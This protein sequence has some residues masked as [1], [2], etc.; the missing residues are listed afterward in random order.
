MPAE[1]HT[2]IELAGTDRPGLL[3]EV[4]AVLADLHCNVVNAEIWTHNA[5]A[6]AVVHVTDDSMGCAI[7]D[8]KR[9]STIK[10]LLCN[11]LKGSDDLKTAKTT[12]SAPGVMHRERR[13]HQIM[14]ADRDYERVEKA[15]VRAVEEGSSRPQ[16]TLLNIE[17]DY[18]VVTMRSKDRPKLLFDIVCTLTD[19]QYVVFH[20]MVN[21]GRIEAYQRKIDADVVIQFVLEFYSEFYIRHVDGLPISSE[22]E[23]V[24]VIQ[25][26]EAAIER[27]ASEGLELELC[28]DDRLGL[29][30]DITR[31]FRE[32]SLCI[33]RALISTKGGKAKD[34]FYVTDVTGNPVDPKIIDS[35]RAQIGHTALQVKFMR[36]VTDLATRIGRALIS[37]SNHATP[38]PTWTPSLEQTLLRLGCRE[39]LTPS[40]VA[41]VI[42]SFPFTHHSLALGFFNWA[43]R[44]PGFSHDSISYQSILKSLSSSRQFNAIEALLKQVKAQKLSLDPSVYRF[45]I[46]SLIKG[47]KTQNAIWVFNEVNSL[48]AELGSELCN[49]LLATSVSDGYFVESQKV[50]DEMFQKGIV[51]NTIGLGLFIW[52]TCKN[53]ELSKVLSLLDEV[54]KGSSWDVNGSIIAVLVVHGLCFSSRESEAFWALDELR[55]RGC[56]PDFIAY[57]IVAEAFRM[58][59]N[60]VERELVLKKKR[61]LGVAPRSN[62]YREFILGL[63]LERRISE[64][65]DLGEAIVSGNFPIEDDVLNALIG[66]VSRIDPGS[67]IMFLNFMVGKGRLPTLS[68]LSNLSKNLCK[69][70]KGDELWE[71]YQVLSSHGYFSDLESYNVMVSFFCRAGRLREAYKVLQEMKTKGLSPNVL[72]YN[73]LMEACCKEDLVRPAKRLWDEMFA[74]GCPGNLSTYNILIGKLSQIGEV[75]E[76]TRLFRH[77]AEKGVTPDATTYTALLEGLCQESDFKS[78]FEIFNKSVEQDVRLAQTILGTFVIHLCRKGQF[79]VASKLLCVLNSDIAHSDTHVVM[80][81]WLA[82]AKEIQ[83]AIKHI[84]RVRGTSPSILQAIFSKLVASVSS[85]SGPNSTEQLLQAIQEEGPVGCKIY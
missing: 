1:E 19:M 34:T 80:L 54:K 30:S 72:F 65:R 53:G 13:L 85:T 66:S 23:R 79:P 29:L 76:A 35:I 18:T 2:S 57:S 16:V 64:A 6:A 60:V 36:T 44:K 63:I 15:G 56:K 25:C 47:K 22:A 31:I 69:R 71:V 73:H 24:R 5:R 70:S 62:D 26:L 33:R 67:A 41:R 27:R 21:T 10:E 74:S 48:S 38:N 81:K 75:E 17:K 49:S 20:G 68:T 61:K 9:L 32:N 84:Q 8:P 51:F 58:T 59:N 42:D 7:S 52:S 55:S 4:C 37:A 43:S 46:S 82:D 39:S 77:M 50:F 11:V 78:A 45:I 12:L 83:L 40:L 28:T 14:F 3:S